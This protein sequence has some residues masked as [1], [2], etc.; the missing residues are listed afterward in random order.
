MSRVC[1]VNVEKVGVEFGI[2]GKGEGKVV[3]YS[4]NWTKSGSMFRE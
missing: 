2:E 1:R 3:R 4:R